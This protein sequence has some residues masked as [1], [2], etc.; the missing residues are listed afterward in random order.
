LRCEWIH[1][2]IADFFNTIGPFETLKTS[3]LIVGSWR[4][5]DLQNVS[6]LCLLTGSGKAHLHG[7][8]RREAVI[9]GST[10]GVCFGS[11]VRFRNGSV[12]AEPDVQDPAKK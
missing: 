3:M 4:N 5:R 9:H 7:R 6:R 2:F 10:T 1:G 12:A 11:R 8:Y